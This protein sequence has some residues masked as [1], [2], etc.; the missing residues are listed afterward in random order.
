MK[1]MLL[2]F[3]AIIT[4]LP[5]SSCSK[6]AAD[7][8]VG[9]WENGC[10][11]I[12]FDVDGT[13]KMWRYGIVY[14]GSYQVEGPNIYLNFS[15]DLGGDDGDRIFNGKITNISLFDLTLKI[16]DNRLYYWR[17]EKPLP[18]C[19][20]TNTGATISVTGDAWFV[21]DH[22]YNERERIQLENVTFGLYNAVDWGLGQ[23]QTLLGCCSGNGVGLNITQTAECSG[24]F[25]EYSNVCFGI[26]DEIVFDRGNPFIDNTM[27]NGYILY[28]S[29]MV[30]SN[31]EVWLNGERVGFSS[32]TNYPSQY[33]PN[34]LCYCLFARDEFGNNVVQNQT[35]ALGTVTFTDEQENVTAKYIP[36]LDD[37]GTP[38]FY[39]SVS[40]ATIYHS[41]SGT[42]IFHA[43]N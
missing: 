1:K 10:E 27:A 22:R 23:D 35:A 6:K 5:F 40:G 25:G 15:D 26:Y 38:C 20:W 16:D 42:P 29:D 39:N 4:L 11:I 37:N 9:C 28:N 30:F 12:Q 21:F 17:R 41:G 36:M 13:M 43:G 32:V 31:D 8:I 7:M 3:I 33:G 19:T 14:E 34:E 18:V 24:P 2:S